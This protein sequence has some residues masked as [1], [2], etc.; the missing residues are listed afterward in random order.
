MTEST[1]KK[2]RKLAK[3]NEITNAEIGAEMGV[4]DTYVAYLLNGSRNPAD[5]EQRLREAIER[6]LDR[7]KEENACR[8]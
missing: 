7:R 3:G 6:I 1:R 5:G 4:S 2:L 8:S